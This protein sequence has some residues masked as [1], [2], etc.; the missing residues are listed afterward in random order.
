M[1]RRMIACGR[2][3]VIAGWCF[4]RTAGFTL[5]RTFSFGTGSLLPRPMPILLVPLSISA[6]G[7]GAILAVRSM[8]ISPQRCGDTSKKFLNPS[9][10]IRC[11][12]MRTLTPIWP[13]E[14][15]VQPIARP[16][17]RSLTHF[18]G[19]VLNANE[20]EIG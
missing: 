9:L 13:P 4:A 19:L 7:S 1:V 18:H 20:Q 8:Y 2:I 3:A 6:L 17:H 14:L 10:H 12:G 5:D 16:E 15:N 11:F